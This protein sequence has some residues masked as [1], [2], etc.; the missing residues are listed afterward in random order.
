MLEKKEGQL[1]NLII[2][3][4]TH[5]TLY[6]KNNVEYNENLASFVGDHGAREFLRYKFGT[7]SPQYRTYE[8]SKKN[9]AK[10]I[11][12]ILHGADLLDSLY[13]SFTYA[14]DKADKEKL[15]KELIQKIMDTTDTL[16]YSGNHKKR[17][18]H[19]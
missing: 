7:D 14:Y 17:H 1:A 10:Y 15:K 12:H 5:A 4:L 8:H 6:I 13:K 16:T 11:Q 9:Q 19:P 18:S 2:H 3:E